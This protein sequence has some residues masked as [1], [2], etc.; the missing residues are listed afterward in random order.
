MQKLDMMSISVSKL[1]CPMCWDFLVVLRDDT[2]LMQVCGHHLI[3]FPVHLPNFL[4][5]SVVQKMVTKYQGYLHDEL[6]KMMGSIRP[7]VKTGKTHVH[8][9]SGESQLG[10]SKARSIMS[11]EYII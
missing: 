10:L 11:G 4:P 8:N 7:M 6:V 3:I 9:Y 2:E 5:D 1:C